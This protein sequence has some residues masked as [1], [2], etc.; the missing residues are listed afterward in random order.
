[1]HQVKVQACDRGMLLSSDPIPLIFLL[2]V[3]KQ[4]FQ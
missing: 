1:M 3:E 4:N 2:G